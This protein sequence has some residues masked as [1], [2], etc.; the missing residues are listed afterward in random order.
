MSSK[1]T[2]ESFW[3]KVKV[4]NKTDCWEWLGSCNN[5]GYGTVAWS[6]TVFTAHRV[7]AYLS[8]MV[9]SMS[10]PKNAK[11]ST[12]ILHKCDNRKCCNPEHFFLGSYT[13]NQIDAYKK[14]RKTQPQGEH[15]VNAK[16]SKD[17]V[18]EIRKRYS[19]GEL[20]IPLAHEFKVSQRCISLIVRGES[21]KCI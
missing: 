6:G 12:H 19:N 15:H 10:A 14:R 20:Q 18:M 5:T 17:Q 7:A 1:Q 3:N 9:T 21:Y 8:G 2:E 11:E 4:L 13:D 16:L